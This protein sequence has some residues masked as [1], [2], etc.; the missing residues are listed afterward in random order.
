MQ[1]TRDISEF[2]ALLLALERA[3]RLRAL[4]RALAARR[5]A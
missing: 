4:L 2:L 1:P 3:R 5:A